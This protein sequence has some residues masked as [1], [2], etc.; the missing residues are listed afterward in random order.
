MCVLP[1]EMVTSDDHTHSINITWVN[2][3][4]PSEVTPLD[5]A[6]VQSN[7]SFLISWSPPNEANG[8]I[9]NYIVTNQ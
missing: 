2:S 7:T 4:V 6:S 8:I 3:T 1:T 5:V 9:T